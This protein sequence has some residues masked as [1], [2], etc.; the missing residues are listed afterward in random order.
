MNAIDPIRTPSQSRAASRPRIQHVD[1]PAAGRMIGACDKAAALGFTHLAMPPPFAAGRTGDRFLPANLTEAAPEFGG[2]AIGDL[3]E[4]LSAQCANAGLQLIIDIGLNRLAAE[5]PGDGIPFHAVAAPVALDPRRLAAS[6]VRIAMDA[7]PEQA[8]ALG[9]WWGQ[10]VAA[11]QGHGVA[12]VRLV[13]LDALS[14]PGETVA[15]IRAAAPGA[16]LIGWTPGM[17]EAALGSLNGAGLDFVAS[18]L[19]WWD[20]RSD[21]LWTELDRLQRIAP[22]LGCPEAP[23]GPRLAAGV[24]EP[25]MLEAIYRRTAALAATLGDGW[26]VPAGFEHGARRAMPRRYEPERAADSNIDFADQLAALN[27]LAANPAWPQPG[28]RDVPLLGGS[29]SVLAV[30]KADADPRFASRGVLTII[31]ADPA[32]TRTV[33]IADLLPASAN[34]GGFTSL[35]DGSVVEAGAIVTLAPGEMQTFSA[36]APKLRA[37]LPLTVEGARQAGASPRVAIENPSPCVDDGVLPAKRTQGE[38]LAVEADIVCDGHDKLG[39]VV[40]WR[41]PGETAWQESRMRLLGNDRWTGSFPLTELGA[42]EYDIQAWRDAFASYRDELAKKSVAGVSVTSELLEGIAFLAHAAEG[43]GGAARETLEAAI[44]AL[45]DADEPARCQTLLSDSVAAAMA[46]LDDRPRAATLRSPVRVDAERIGARFASWYE[47][48]PRSLSDDP[49]RHGTFADVQRHLP[50][51]RDMGFDV[52]YFPPIHPIGRK[53]R[54]GRNNTLTPAADD[55]GSP[56]AIGSDEGGHDALHSELGT[57]ED[58]QALRRA[59]EAHG[60]EL[61]IDFAIQCSPDHPWLREHHGWF[62]WRPDGTIKYAENPPKRYEDIVNVDFYAADAVPGL[63]MALAETVMF[64]AEQG[65]RLFRVDN[66]HTKPFPFWEWMI[67]EVRASY[68]DAVFLAEAFTRPKVMYRL[69]KVGFSQ[70]YTYFTWRETK[71]EMEEYL[72]ELSTEGPREFFRPHFFVNTPDINPVFLQNSGRP[73]FLI[74]AALAATLSGLWG[75]YNGFELCEGTPVPGK[76]E[77]LDSEKYQL[78][79]WDWDRPGNIVAEI[80]QLNR[81]RRANPALW[82]HLD[83]AFQPAANDAV[84][85][86]EKANADRSNVIMAAI[87]FDPKQ[88]QETA[89][90]FPFWHWSVPESA[91]FDVENLVTG[92]LATWRGKNQRVRLT[93]EQP[94]AIWRIRAAI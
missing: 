50:R 5:F 44:Q 23:F 14:H 16:T 2:G 45:A 47:V 86:F 30:L 8:R 34:L 60:L 46:E 58:F 69:A 88:P 38:W 15:G 26:L 90:E 94:Y 65:V 72:T 66:P 59:A 74:R 39:A 36:Q 52:L 20:W 55:P 1:L 6:P 11:L 21:W 41:G 7:Q 56:Y 33:A 67:G 87:S 32:R 54:K 25:G 68:P 10:A 49:T 19:P 42:Y 18:S 82:T 28:G 48:F 81:I 27:A 61:A 84:T 77:Y 29:A 40:R 37:M 17:A 89:F 91:P 62:N 79:A 63:W 71:R 35:Q 12:G 53:N 76:E 13:G 24:H 43:A 3:L 78:R 73:G 57:F 75:V 93:P 85:V 51:I 64:W 9:H 22:V 92:E 70:S 80:T 31:N 83:V 4:T